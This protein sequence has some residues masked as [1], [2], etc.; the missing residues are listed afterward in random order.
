MN[1][2][3]SEDVILLAGNANPK[4]AQD[5]A[6]FLG[7]KLCDAKISKFSDGEISVN[8]LESVR[9]KDVFVIQYAVPPA[10]DNLMELLILIDALRRASAGRINVVSPYYGYA[11]QDRKDKS[12]VPITAKL[13]ANLISIAGAD[14]LIAV[15]LHSDQ[16][17]GFFDIPV[18]RL[19]ALP[20]IAEYI[21]S[22]AF[23]LSK[24]VVVAP[25]AGGVKNARALAERLGLPM[26]IIDKR[27][28][29]ENVSEV[30]YVIGDVA[31]MDVVMIDDII[32]TAGTIVNAAYALKDLGVEKVFAACTHPVLSGPA[33]ERIKDSPIE[34]LFVTDTIELPEG[35]RIDKIEVISLAELLASAIERIHIGASVSVLF[36]E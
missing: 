35:K 3:Y 9:E 13:V 7:V 33:I 30:Q 17:M 4:L 24:L 12:R 29:K 31:G 11:R 34:Q 32:D 19:Q 5:I 8:I 25:D 36:E 20:I 28:P 27:R 15:D 23:D 1:L 2:T 6:K 21:K 18:D 14:R 16:I 10:N 26:A 22:H